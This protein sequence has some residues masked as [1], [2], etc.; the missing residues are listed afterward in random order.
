MCDVSLLRKLYNDVGN[1]VRNL[2]A[3]GVLTSTYGSLLV[4]ILN[5]RIPD[6]LRVIISRKFGNDPWTLDKMFIYL[7]EEILANER[8]RFSECEHRCRS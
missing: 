6:E 1:C 4:P 7:S 5:D 3:L 2:K 8:C